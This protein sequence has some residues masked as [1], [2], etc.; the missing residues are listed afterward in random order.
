MRG[1]SQVIIHIW[2]R[3]LQATDFLPPFLVHAHAYRRAR[4]HTQ[5]LSPFW[6]INGFPL[7]GVWSCLDCW[8]RRVSPL[9]LEAQITGEIG[10]MVAPHGVRQFRVFSALV[11]G[12]IVYCAKRWELLSFSQV[13]VIPPPGDWCRRQGNMSF[14]FPASMN[15][16]TCLLWRRRWINYWRGTTSDWGRTLEVCAGSFFFFFLNERLLIY[17]WRHS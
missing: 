8:F 1:R 2:L 9:W 3:T 12:S 7:N 17:F 6:A 4:S 11:V 13:K 5:R 14:Y 10:V 15:R 16:A